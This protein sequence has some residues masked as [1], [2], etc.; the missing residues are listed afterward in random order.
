MK[1]QPEKLSQ[2]VH[3]FLIRRFIIMTNYPITILTKKKTFRISGI[4]KNNNPKKKKSSNNL[5]NTII[6]IILMTIWI[7]GKILKIIKM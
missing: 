4:S 6:I 7:K 3:S 1:N 2:S 5:L